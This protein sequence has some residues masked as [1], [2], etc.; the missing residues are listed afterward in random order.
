MFICRKKSLGE[1]KGKLFK[2]LQLKKTIHIIFKLEKLERFLQKKKIINSLKRETKLILCKDDL[3]I[4]C[5]YVKALINKL[6]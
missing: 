5:S 1:R 4:F 6:L 2:N 3:L